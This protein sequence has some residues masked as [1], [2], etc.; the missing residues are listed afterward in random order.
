MMPKTLRQ[1][2]ACLTDDGDIFN[3]L[4]F[5]NAAPAM[6]GGPAQESFRTDHGYHVTK[7]S[8]GEYFLTWTGQR[9][10]P[11]RRSAQDF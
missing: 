1:I 6:A 2:I 8:E 11:I 4:N 10:T 3:V 5:V 7:V 9:M